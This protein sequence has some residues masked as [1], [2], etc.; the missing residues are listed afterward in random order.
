MK[1]FNTRTN[2]DFDVYSNDPLK[3]GK[4]TICGRS[5]TLDVGDIIEHDSNGIGFQVETIK[6]RDHKGIFK[7]PE[8]KKNSFY[9]ATCK[10]VDMQEIYEQLEKEKNV[11]ES[12]D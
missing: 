6:R 11:E 1:I 9:T 5:T 2:R 10:R 12:K 7:K 4:Y 8:D 3:G